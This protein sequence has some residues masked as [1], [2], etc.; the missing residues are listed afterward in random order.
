MKPK[1]FLIVL[2]LLFL[3][4]TILAQTAQL[5]ERTDGNLIIASYNIKWIGDIQH[6][7]DKLAE[8]IQHFDICGVIEIKNESALARLADSL[9]K[10]T[11]KDWG[12]VFG[13]R[14]SRPN[15]SYYETYGVVWRKDR[16]ELGDGMISGIWDNKE[17][18]RNDPYTVSFKRKNFD[19]I[20]FLIHTRWSDDSD[21]TREKEIAATSEYILWLRS[22]LTERDLVLAGDFN[23]SGNE[24]VM[25]NMAEDAN[26]TQ[27]DSN[28]KSTF[29][30]D[31]SG[32]GSSYDHIYLSEDALGKFVQGKCGVLDSTTL[33][34]GNRNAENMKKSKQEL[35][36]HLPVW[37][38]FNVTLLDDDK[39][40]NNIYH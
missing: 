31:Y 27:I 17:V 3:V 37:A 30:N 33:I 29:K 4:S 38:V 15:G 32:Y 1:S 8:V 18:F 40:I 25:K 13:V 20:L 9:R 10:K 11:Q 12:F 14:T 34:Y 39:L 5:P 2:G 16:V 35:S 22:F 23:Y 28:E 19:F 26:L 24:S 7:Y 21:G 36:D 6:N